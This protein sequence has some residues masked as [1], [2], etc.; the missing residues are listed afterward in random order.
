MKLPS[1]SHTLLE[2]LR[3]LKRFPA[4]VV[5][6]MAGT[7][8]AM[9]LLGRSTSFYEEN[10]QLI[11]L[12]LTCSLMLPAFVASQLFFELRE[13]KP[14]SAL[15]AMFLL[16]GIFAIYFYTLPAKL[17]YTDYIFFSLIN[18]AL[19]LGV[20][21]SP[22]TRKGNENGFWQFNKVLF[23]RVLAALLYSHVLF[24][25]LSL[26]LLAIENLFDVNVDDKLYGRLWIFILGIF[27]TMFFLGGIPRD[28]S[29]LEKEQAYP[30]G[31]KVFTQYVLLPL[32]FIYLVILYAYAGKIVVQW[33]W[34]QGW[35][36]YLVLGFSGLSILSFLLIYPLQGT[37]GNR[38][39]ALF[40]KWFYLLL[41]PLIVL[42]ALAVFR[43]IHEYGI[44]ENRYFLV[45]L[46][47]W[48]AA[49]TVYFLLGRKKNIKVIPLSLSALSLLI[50]FGPWGAFGTAMRSQTGRFKKVLEQ[51][52]MLQEGHIVKPVQQV[53]FGDQKQLSS[54]LSFL[55]DRKALGEIRHYFPKAPDSL[56]SQVSRVNDKTPLLTERM[57]INYIPDWQTED[58]A[59][60][61]NTFYLNAGI[62]DQMDIS[63]YDLLIP[64]DYNQYVDSTWRVYDSL[65]VTFNA[66]L[67][68]IEFFKN[69]ERIGSIPM[70]PS[71]DVWKEKYPGNTY[72][73]DIAVEELTILEET[74]HHRFKFYLR[75]LDASEE[76]GKINVHNFL[77]TILIGN[78]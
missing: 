52:Q 46:T 55:E 12:V 6:T 1:L 66:T 32:V 68:R 60:G 48:L 10:Y 62:D 50:S 28:P 39:I 13:V 70:G 77:G 21:F 54:I 74:D 29:A 47:A 38:W 24:V 34:P 37:A 57:G 64:F 30:K 3:L 69:E 22:F 4:A 19:H 43:R 61:P 49:I 11:N 67:K 72:D 41:L 18:L 59:A 26:A 36:S 53:D 15:A 44:T 76:N 71:L 14:K 17:S 25:G 7:I 20:A 75:T 58:Y 23:I 42:L 8:A 9:V 2:L 63:G 78:K 16:V 51:N 33:E 27:N 73:G 56:F 31:L 35:V 40:L 65:N 5:A 45:I